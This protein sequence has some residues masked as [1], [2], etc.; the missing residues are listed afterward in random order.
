MAEP[1]VSGATPGQVVFSAIKQQ[2]HPVQSKPVSSRLGVSIAIMKHHGPKQTGEKV[3]LAY[4]SASLLTTEG[5]Q[6]MNANT[7]GTCSQELV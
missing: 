4:T 1:L 2:A 5:S 3:Y 6:G 7:A